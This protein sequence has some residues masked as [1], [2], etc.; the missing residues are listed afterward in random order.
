M[1][2]NRKH[3]SSLWFHT[4]PSMVANVGESPSG[5]GSLACNI[6]FKLPQ[7]PIVTLCGH[8][9]CWPCL[10]KW[11]RIH[12]HSPKC[13][14]CKAV[15]EEDKLVPLYGSNKDSVDPRSKN[16]VRGGLAD[17]THQLTWHGQRPAMAPQAGPNRRPLTSMKIKR[18][19]RLE[20]DDTSTAC[21][22]S[23][24]PPQLEVRN[25]H[26]EGMTR[27]FYVVRL[28]PLVTLEIEGSRT[29]VSVQTRR[30]KWIV[31]VGSCHSIVFDTETEDVIHGP[32]LIN[33]KECPV[34]VAVEDKIY[35]LSS[36]PKVKGKLDFEPWFEVLDLS[37]AT[38]VDGCLEDC[39]WEELPSPP[40][41]LC[42]QDAQEFLCP[43]VVIVESYVVVGSY[44]LMSIR[45]EISQ[46]HI[47]SWG[48]DILA[49]EFHW[50]KKAT[51]TLKTYQME[52]N[53]L[54]QEDEPLK[55]A[56]SE[57]PEQ[58]FKIHTKSGGFISPAFLAILKT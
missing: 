40:C 22:R 38:V 4:R 51:I 37:H 6:F 24:D 28:H 33:G 26:T 29:F 7:E 32:K 3:S 2:I 9:F 8:L 35:A 1:V 30:Y 16:N 57:Q 58:A 43:H 55:I 46:T 42:Q 18:R 15:V 20:G 39:A 31:V 25:Q 45:L 34:L 36:F 53:S 12:S 41:F 47:H 50:S 13:P 21:P 19:R 5:R 10:C 11:L 23:D 49:D 54:L 44:I 48:D 52:D 14:V 17:I 27:S 56:I